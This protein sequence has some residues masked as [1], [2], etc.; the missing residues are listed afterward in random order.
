MQ[1]LEALNQGAQRVQ[2][3]DL[4]QDIQNEGDREFETVCSTFNAMRKHILNEQEK[5]HKY[6]KARMDMLRGISHDLK[7]PLTSFKAVLKAS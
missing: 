2:E 7:T 3:N 5:N 1:P 6:E 4:T